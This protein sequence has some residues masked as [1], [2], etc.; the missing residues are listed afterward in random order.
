MPVR[1]E[2]TGLKSHYIKSVACKSLSLQACYL[3][4]LHTIPSNSHQPTIRWEQRWK[5][6][7]SDSSEKIEKEK[8][9]KKIWPLHNWKSIIKGRLLSC[10]A[11]T[12]L[13]WYPRNAMALYNLGL[14]KHGVVQEQYW[15][16]ATE[17]SESFASLIRGV[18]NRTSQ[19]CVSIKEIGEIKVK[20]S[21]WWTVDD[22][23]NL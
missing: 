19:V 2:T 1:N 15:G 3:A 10:Q 23:I 4:L 17:M 7:D 20:F 11:I 18:N 6:K 13:L 12:V 16:R 14:L 22:S 8:R 5:R 21:W 9:R